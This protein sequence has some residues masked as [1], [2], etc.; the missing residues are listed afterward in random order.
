M[1]KVEHAPVAAAAEKAEQLILIP[2]LLAILP[3]LAGIYCII[4]F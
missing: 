3:V 1:G 2:A 4:Q